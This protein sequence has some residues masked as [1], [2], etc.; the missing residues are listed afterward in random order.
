M[1]NYPTVLDKPRFHRMRMHFVAVC[2]LNKETWLHI[3]KE[4][5][6]DREWLPHSNQTDQLGIPLSEQ[7]ITV[8]LQMMAHLKGILT[9]EILIP[10]DVIRYII[11]NHPPDRSLNIARLLDD[12]PTDLFNTERLW[13]DGID[14]K[15]L[16]DSKDS[17]A[18][19]LLLFM[20]A[21]QSFSGPFGL[22]NAVR[23]N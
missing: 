5:D 9:G 13:R 8:W 11:P 16:E 18:F 6:D 10:G 17:N 20:R 12:P 14:P 2:K 7:Q 15:Y 23:L 1:L 22:F 4:T 3:R 21:A 19:D